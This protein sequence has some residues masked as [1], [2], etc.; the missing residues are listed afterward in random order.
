MLVVFIIKDEFNLDDGLYLD[1]FLRK[2]VLVF[3]FFKCIY[4]CGWICLD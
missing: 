1:F 3:M 2:D 4:V